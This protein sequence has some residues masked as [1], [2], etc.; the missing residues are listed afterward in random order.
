MITT[1][2]DRTLELDFQVTVLKKR[3]RD[4][5]EHHEQPLLPPLRQKRRVGDGGG[6]MQIFV[7]TLNGKTITLEVEADDTIDYVK[8]FIFMKEG[9][10]V[11][12]QR[13]IY[14]GKR[15]ED[16]RTLADYNIQKGSTLHLALR[17]R[18]ILRD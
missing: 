9:I 16:D 10:P 4:L 8:Q 15:L 2:G 5:E 13:L 18:G 14:G 6:G 11:D 17:L 7:K 12:N 1:I 3:L